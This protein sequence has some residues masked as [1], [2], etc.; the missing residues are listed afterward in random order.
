MGHKKHSQTLYT[1]HIQ[2]QFD[3]QGTWENKEKLMQF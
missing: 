2:M 1:K 3:S